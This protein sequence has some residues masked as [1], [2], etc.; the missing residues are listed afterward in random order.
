MIV[1]DDG[2]IDHSREIIAGYGD[3]IIPVLKENGGQ[4]SAFNAGF[5][6]SRGEVIFF[7]DADDMLLPGAVEKALEFFHN[8]DIVKLHWPLWVIDAQGRKTGQVFPGSTLPEGDFR[9]VVLRNGPSSS[10]SPPTTGNAWARS[11]LDR[12]F[13]IPNGEYK[14]CA[15]DYLYALAPAFGPIKRISEAQGLYRIHG[16]NNY[17]SKTFEEKLRLGLCVQDQQCLVLSKFFRDMGIN[18]DP[19]VWKRN[20]WFHRLH[21]A[22]EEIV[23]LIP[24]GKCFILVDEDQWGTGEVF[25]RRCIPFLEQA[26]HYGGPPPDDD[27]AIRELERLREAGASFMVF[28]WPAFWWLEHYP[29]LHHH[30][31]TN[32]RCVLANDR[33][34]VFDLQRCG[35]TI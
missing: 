5:A 17:Q 21:R 27:T 26:G 22:T 12:V 34:V 29:A 24:A 4:A 28:A 19:G 14:I 10:A 35:E 18:V 20:L 8:P 11:F 15:D 16:Q 32:C 33:L 30:L 23:I 13:P 31:R 2:S 3:R 7:L 25:G 1:V 9:D 6:V